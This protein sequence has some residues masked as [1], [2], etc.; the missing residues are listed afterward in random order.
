MR[1]SDADIVAFTDD[2]A[3]PEPHWLAALAA[4]FQDPRVVCATGLTLPASLDTEA[5]ELFERNCSFVRGFRRRVFDGQRDN[6]L[7]VGQAGA[8]A[9]MAVRRQRV[10]ELGGFDP[11]LD[12]G[13][14][15][16][17]GG[18][19]EIFTRILAAGHRIVYEPAAVSRHRHRRTMP[20][21]LS[22]VRG[23]GIGVY[24]MWTGLLLERREIGVLRLAWRWFAQ[25]QLTALCRRSA[26]RRLA[27]TELAGC[28]SGPAAWLA[29]D[30]AHRA[31]D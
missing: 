25:T 21:L 13:T 3:A 27:T 6:P 29:S 22:T 20:E 31:N 18:D 16:R 9:N 1:E 15:T 12:A 11:R 5:Q 7:H 26:G 10:I 24:A 17:S 19:H 8:G 4:N 14:A 30:R 2:D 28:L 23:Y